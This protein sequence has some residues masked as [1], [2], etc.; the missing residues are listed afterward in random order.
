[1]MRRVLPAILAVLIATTLSAAVATAAVRVGPSAVKACMNSHHVLV[2]A[3]KKGHCPKGDSKASVALSAPPPGPSVYVNREHSADTINEH[4]VIN[5]LS[6]PKG[7]YM[8]T[9]VTD[10]YN[11]DTGADNASCSF[12]AAGQNGL[13]RTLAAPEGPSQIVDQDVVMYAKATKVQVTCSSSSAAVA[14]Y[15]NGAQTFTAE[16]VTTG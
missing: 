9:S 7:A 8:L 16:A 3:S 14:Y 15:G 11:N 2:L 5:T 12:Q 4:D 10:I 1:M 6:L 13:S